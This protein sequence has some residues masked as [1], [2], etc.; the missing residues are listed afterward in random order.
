MY[1]KHYVTNYHINIQSA[2]FFFFFFLFLFLFLV[3][4]VVSKMFLFVC[5]KLHEQFFRDLAA[6]SIICDRAVT[7]HAYCD[8]GPRFERPAPISHR[9]IRTQSSDL[10][11]DAL[12]TAKRWRLDVSGGVILVYNEK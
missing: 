10:C 3:S 12:T 4:D 7:Y 2:I 5:L 11:A 8:T 9:R 1:A 6:V